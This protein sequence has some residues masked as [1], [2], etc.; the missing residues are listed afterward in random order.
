MGICTAWPLGWL[1]I[2]WTCVVKVAGLVNIKDR[3]VPRLTGLFREFPI[4]SQSV[5]Q[6]VGLRTEG[7]MFKRESKA[8]EQ[9]LKR[10]SFTVTIPM[11][12]YQI[13]LVDNFFYT[14][15]RRKIHY[16]TYIHG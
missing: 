5:G 6:P 13:G 8:K 2:R 11:I 14:F 3:K 7:F 16:F 4:S 15:E 10:P 12:N 1:V 9:M